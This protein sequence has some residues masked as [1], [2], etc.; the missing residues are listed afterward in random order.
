MIESWVLPAWTGLG[1][2][3]FVLLIPALWMDYLAR[4][5]DKPEQMVWW[6]SILASYGVFILLGI[7]IF[8][9]V[10]Y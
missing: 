9:G 8:W 6:W 7:S 10:V 4:R 5:K 2:V 1:W 3:M